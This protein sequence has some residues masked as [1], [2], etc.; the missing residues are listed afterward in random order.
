[1]GSKEYAI[2]CGGDMA[3]PGTSS[4]KSILNTS[5]E[6]HKSDKSVKIVEPT[7]YVCEKKIKEF[8][9]KVDALIIE[10]IERRRDEFYE[11]KSSVLPR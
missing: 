2:I 8:R 9:L 3:S 4:K 11:L 5:H 1:M 7:S 6:K 10:Q